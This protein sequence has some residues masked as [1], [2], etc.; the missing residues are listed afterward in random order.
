MAESLKAQVL[1]PWS[2]RLR[3][4]QMQAELVEYNRTEAHGNAKYVLIMQLVIAVVALVL[5]LLMKRKT[6]NEEVSNELI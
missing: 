1:S 4:P 5:G 2:L 6:E 3:S